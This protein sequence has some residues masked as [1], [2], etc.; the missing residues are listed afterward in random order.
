VLGEAKRNLG[1][2][3]TLADYGRLAASTWSKARVGP[4]QLL[5]PALPWAALDYSA[6]DHPNVGAELF[7]K[8]SRQGTGHGFVA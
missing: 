8:V 2:I 6:V 7:W 4:H 5:A 1:L 3:Y